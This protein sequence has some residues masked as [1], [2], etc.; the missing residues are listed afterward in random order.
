MAVDRR[1]VSRRI[2]SD[3]SPLQGARHGKVVEDYDDVAELEASLA[4]DEYGL[5]D[6]L[7]AQPELFYRVAKAL[8]LEVSRRDAAKQA[9]AD[10]EAIV[11]LDQRRIAA[12]EDR[13][14]TEGEIKAH[15]QTNSRVG[16]ARQRF[17]ARSEAS[18]KLGALKEAFQQRSYALKDLAG[19][20]VANY[21]SASEDSASART[22]RD[23]DASSARAAM[24]AERRRVNT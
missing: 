2:S 5:D 10:V 18:A 9:L 7:R 19:L 12:E 24:A 4:I 17:A 22:V 11:D 13:K 6:A 23:R 8:A 14:I 15:V 3:D 16:G 1:Q 21:Y 20:Y